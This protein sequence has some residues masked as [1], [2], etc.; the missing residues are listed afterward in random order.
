MAVCTCVDHR[1]LRRCV[2][3]SPHLN[4]SG[5]PRD[6]RETIFGAVADRVSQWCDRLDEPIDQTLV[7]EVKEILKPIH[8]WV[9]VEGK[10]EDND[11]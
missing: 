5:L 9:Y 4:S 7:A 3:F 1:L 6:Q 2:L 8:N 10:P 11:D